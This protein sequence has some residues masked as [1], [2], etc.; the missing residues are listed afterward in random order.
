MLLQV[1]LLRLETRFHVV[2]SEVLAEPERM[3]PQHHLVI[4]S[5]ITACDEGTVCP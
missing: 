4:A 2:F 3:E 5:I 1:I